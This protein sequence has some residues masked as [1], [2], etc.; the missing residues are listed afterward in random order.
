LLYLKATN[1]KKS[2]E[3]QEILSFKELNIYKGNKI[4]LVG[5]NGSGKSTLFKILIEEIKPDSGSVEVFSTISYFEQISDLFQIGKVNKDLFKLNANKTVDNIKM[6]GGEETKVRLTEALEK[7]AHL[8]LFDE[9]TTNLDCIEIEFLKKQLLNIETFIIISHDRTILNSFCNSIIE[10]KN[11]QLYFY[12]GNYDDYKRMERENFDRGNFEYGQYIKEKKRLERMYEDKK[13]KI[14]KSNRGMYKK[15]YSE[16]KVVNS[17]V[18]KT[19]GS[20]K[21]SA[22]RSA[23]AILTRIEHLEVKEKFQVENKIRPDLS[24]TNPPK[25]KFV[26]TVDNLNFKYGDNII[27]KNASINVKNGEHVVIMGK[28]GSGKT[29][30]LNLISSQ[31]TSVRWNPKVKVGMFYQKLENINYEMT[32]LENAIKN[33]IQN[34]T[35]NRNILARMLFSEED[36]KKKAELLSGGERVKLSFVKLFLSDCNTLLLDEP[37]N[38]LDIPSIEALEGVLNDYEGTI[39]FASHDETF[40]DKVVNRKIVIENFSFKDESVYHSLNLNGD[41]ILRLEIE[42]A[43]LTSKLNLGDEKINKRYFEVSN[44]IKSLKKML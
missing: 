18:S 39:I 30:F 34:D 16:R 9:P 32:V 11:K 17:S 44:I 14:K 25:S 22:E 7:N 12:S 2:F 13:E 6:S 24:L 10:I 35:V 19:P 1:I 15:S 28:N 31:N 41:E 33:S 38:F 26:L 8:Y 36:L 21:K 40:I 42:L 43:E 37:T 23:K 4:G 5:L 29:T 3:E 20:K 27:F